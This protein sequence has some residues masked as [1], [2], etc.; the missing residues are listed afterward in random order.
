MK[1]GI[2][3]GAWVGDTLNIFKDFDLVYAFEPNKFAFEKLKNNVGNDSKYKLFD[4]AVSNFTGTQ[5]FHAMES[6]GLSSLLIYD[7]DGEFA[8][9]IQR[10]SSGE[11]IA[12]IKETYD[13]KTIRLSDFFEQENITHVDYLKIDAQGCDLLVI[14]SL[15]DKVNLVKVIECEAQIK[16]LYKNQPLINDV[17]NYMNNINFEMVSNGYNENPNNQNWESKLV[18]KNKSYA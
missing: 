18:F 16:P 17:I 15:G 1:I 9:E 5:Q 10:R 4:I 7:E 12:K 2:D 3:I 11:N 14:E 6:E 13:V 8:Q